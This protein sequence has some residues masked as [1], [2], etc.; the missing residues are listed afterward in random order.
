M[1][2]TGLRRGTH[3]VD[4]ILAARLRRSNCD[5]PDPGLAP[6][7]RLGWP[8]F[9]GSGPTWW[10]GAPFRRLPFVFGL[11]ANAANQKPVSGFFVSAEVSFACL[12]RAPACL[13]SPGSSVRCALEL[14]PRAWGRY[15]E[16]ALVRPDSD[17]TSRCR[18]VDSALGTEFFERQTREMSPTRRPS[19]TSGGT[20]RAVV[21]VR[22][23]CLRANLRRLS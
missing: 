7:L 9:P 1:R 5:V 21:R 17:F 11:L 20:P 4:R 15:F 2:N 22:P 19:D 3:W 16:L 8:E 6:G 18:I 10:K 23:F 14:M 13:P 12:L